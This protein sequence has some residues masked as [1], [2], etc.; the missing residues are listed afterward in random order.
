M[1]VRRILNT[2]GDCSAAI[3][4]KDT[5][6]LTGQIIRS[7]STEGGHKEGHLLPSKWALQ[8][9]QNISST[10]MHTAL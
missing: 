10:A 2:V 5:T 3:E 8:T 6:S 9:A 4:Y 1:L 7:V